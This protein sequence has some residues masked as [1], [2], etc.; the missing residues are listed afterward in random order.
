MKITGYINFDEKTIEVLGEKVS[1]NSA[2]I[3]Y[4][5][6]D[7]Y[8]EPESRDEFLDFDLMRDLYRQGITNIVFLSGKNV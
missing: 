4:F 6:H 1:F 8:Y 2:G 3:Y 7:N 5:I